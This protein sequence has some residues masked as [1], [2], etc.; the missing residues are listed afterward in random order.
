MSKSFLQ[1]KTV[2]LTCLVCFG[3]FA[4]FQFLYPEKLLA[5]TTNCQYRCVRKIVFSETE[6]LRLCGLL[7]MDGPRTDPYV[8]YL[9]SIHNQQST[10][11]DACSS[12]CHAFC[13][14]GCGGN[15]DFSSLSS[16]YR[17]TADSWCASGG[18]APSWIPTLETLCP[19]PAGRASITLPD[20]VIRAGQA[21]ASGDAPHCTEPPASSRPAGPPA[22][23]NEPA[24]AAGARQGTCKFYCV[25]PDTGSTPAGSDRATA[26]RESGTVQIG[27]RDVRCEQAGV[28]QH[29]LTGTCTIGQQCACR[30]L[31]ES[32]CGVS[33]A[34]KSRCFLTTAD[35]SHIQVCQR[36]PSAA[37]PQC[38]TPPV[39]QTGSP[40]SLTNPLGTEDI[41]VLIARFIKALTGIA[42]AFALLMFV[43]GG[44]IWMTA[45]GSDRV[46]MAKE[47][48][49]N[50]TIGL[51]L[52]FFS[53]A[54]VNLFLSVLGI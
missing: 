14:V 38:V 32:T 11:A 36:P 21:T 26:P 10:T 37:D 30:Q 23:C 49:Q 50:A 8:F 47:I 34:G 4:I 31:C 29:E 40:T 2:L 53:Y 28:V 19:Y 9:S 33:E 7:A 41:G 35:D 17:G 51:L 24:P 15:G 18:T 3:A 22:A 16:S 48:M 20:N 54:L 44:I 5:A 43:A 52:I 1:N 25:N 45:E 42:G 27:G 12:G 6:T 39:A 13:D 46:N